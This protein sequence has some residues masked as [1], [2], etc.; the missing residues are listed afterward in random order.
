[1]ITL[2]FALCSSLDTRLCGLYLCMACKCYTVALD[3]LNELKEQSAAGPA[4]CALIIDYLTILLGY[5][6]FLISL[7]G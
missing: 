6:D 1:M 3:K 5:I 7:V 2:I 4:D